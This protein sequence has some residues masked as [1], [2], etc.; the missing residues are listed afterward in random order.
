MTWGVFFHLPAESVSECEQRTNSLFPNC[1]VPDVGVHYF[2]LVSCDLGRKGIEPGDGRVYAV[3]KVS[4]FVD[5]DKNRFFDRDLGNPMLSKQVKCPGMGLSERLKMKTGGKEQCRGRRN[6]VRRNGSF[7]IEEQVDR[8]EFDGIHF[9]YLRKKN[10]YPHF[11]SSLRESE[12][13]KAG[14]LPSCEIDI[15]APPC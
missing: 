7:F 3:K 9:L 12:L 1:L 8:Y 2:H 5:G 4:K 11:F 14:I 6:H 10:D 15:D 13:R